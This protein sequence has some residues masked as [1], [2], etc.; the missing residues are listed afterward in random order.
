MQI[1]HVITT[2]DRG[3]AENQLVTLIKEQVARGNSV[4]VVD[5][6]GLAENSGALESAGVKLQKIRVKNRKI[7]K[8]SYALRK[9]LAKKQFD[10]IH[11][12]LPRSEIVT[13]LATL[14]KKQIRVS[15]IHNAE[16]FTKLPENISNWIARQIRNQFDQII[17]ITKEVTS[18][19]IENQQIS[20]RK[21]PTTVHYGLEISPSTKSQLTRQRNVIS[22]ARLT[23]QKRIDVLINAAQILKDAHPPITVSIYGEGEDRSKL[24]EQID[25]AGLSNSFLLKGRTAD[26]QKLLQ[27]NL[28]FALTSEYEGLG[29]VLLEAMQAGCVI[30]ASDAPAI[31]EV[32]G[33]LVEQQAAFVFP[34]NDAPKLAELI[35]HALDLSESEIIRIQSTC[36]RY[37]KENFSIQNSCDQV[38]EVYRRA[39]EK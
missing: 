30:V 23:K 13:V 24:Q 36:L 17:T 27:E 6:F 1:L 5:L 8:E 32:L 21:S 37:L 29:L 18:Y 9:F 15:T 10:L 22:V 12:H 31:V 7:L 19:L 14:G 33:S 38:H 28:V 16:H 2:T 20:S 25:K 3:G 11:A 26:V 39:L 4:T 34:R 35:K